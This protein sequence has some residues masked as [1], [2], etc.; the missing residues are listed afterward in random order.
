[1]RPLDSLAATVYRSNRGACCRAENGTL[2]LPCGLRAQPKDIL[3]SRFRS[4]HRRATR[5]GSK[6]FGLSAQ[7]QLNT[8]RAVVS[9]IPG[10]HYISNSWNSR[11]CSVIVAV[12]W[13]W[14][15]ERTV[16][17]PASSMQPFLEQ[18]TMTAT[19]DRHYWHVVIQRKNGRRMLR[20]LNGVDGPDLTHI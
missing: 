1:M 13:V 12:L 20:L 16:V 17:M 9:Q 8:T 2:H 6:K 18:M 11:E 19:A 5:R 4:C 14:F 15:G 10:S 3:Q 7:Y